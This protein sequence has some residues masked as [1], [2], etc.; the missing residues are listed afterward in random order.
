MIIINNSNSPRQ[1]WIIG[2][3]GNEIKIIRKKDN[4]KKKS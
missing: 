4:E 2:G 1:P 3:Y